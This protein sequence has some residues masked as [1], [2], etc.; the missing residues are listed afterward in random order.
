MRSAVVE[1]ADT[2]LSNRCSA[3]SMESRASPADYSKQNMYINHICMFHTI[4]T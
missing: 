4:L 2:N 1:D 3:H